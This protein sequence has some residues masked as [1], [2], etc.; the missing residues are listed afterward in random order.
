MTSCMYIASTSLYLLLIPIN[1]NITPP[2]PPA[3]T[4]CSISICTPNSLPQHTHRL[5]VLIGISSKYK[6]VVAMS[7]EVFMRWE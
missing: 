4:L 6:L 2:L 5:F 3:H 7:P 1:A